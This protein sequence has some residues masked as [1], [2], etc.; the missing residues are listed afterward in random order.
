MVTLPAEAGL[1]PKRRAGPRHAAA[2]RSMNRLRRGDS[3]RFFAHLR[4]AAVHSPGDRDPVHR[5]TRRSRRH[6]PMGAASTRASGRSPQH[7]VHRSVHHGR[8]PS[9]RRQTGLFSRV[10]ACD[11]SF[12][13]CTSW[14][15]E[16]R[17]RIRTGR[18]GWLLQRSWS[19]PSGDVSSHTSAADGG[20][21]VARETAK[22]GSADVPAGRPG[23]WHRRP[24]RLDRPPAAVRSR[25][26]SHR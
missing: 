1:E 14:W 3:R 19:S 8:R 12:M 5:S 22:A 24:C 6:G 23:R 9:A 26:P 7:D 17:C 11:L 16:A 13:T 15:P 18:G 10:P 4:G 2:D 21:A 20:W 25:R